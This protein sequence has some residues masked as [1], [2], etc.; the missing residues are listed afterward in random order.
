MRQV[1]QFKYL[2][3]MFSEDGGTEVAVRA[4][5]T[6]AWIKWREI[7]GVINDKRMPRKLKV[8]MYETVIR[9]VLLYGLVIRALTRKEEKKL[10][11]TEMRMLRRIMRVTW[12][13]R[14][15]NDDIRK[16][17]KVW[18]ITEKG[19]Q[20]KMVWAPAENGRWNAGKR[21][22]VERVIFGKRGRGRPRTRSKDNIKRYL[23]GRNL[24]ENDARVRQLWRSK[25]RAT[26]PGLMGLGL[27]QRRRRHSQQLL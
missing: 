22:H 3:D 27:R 6:K 25:I 23:R 16:E 20:V 26:D 15:S 7:S 8:K 19:M 24:T 10:E 1:G 12:R 4:R 14:K 17:L 18:V 11:T 13:D 2:G 9:P 21:H 5:V